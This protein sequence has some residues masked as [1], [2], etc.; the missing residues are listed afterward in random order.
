MRVLVA[1]AGPHKRGVDVPTRSGRRAVR[2]DYRGHRLD[3]AEP[4][5]GRV[6]PLVPVFPV[7]PSVRAVPIVTPATVI[8]SGTIPGDE[9][10]VTNRQVGVKARGPVS[11][12]VDEAKR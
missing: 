10:N 9:R 12:V 11:D 2:A 1:S 3:A 5:G 4:L 8:T 7:V 6:V